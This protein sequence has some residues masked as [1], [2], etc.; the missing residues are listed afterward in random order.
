MSWK[1]DPFSAVDRPHAVRKAKHIGTHKKSG[2]Y[3]H[4]K[5]RS[6]YGTKT[7]PAAKDKVP[8]PRA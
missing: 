6:F 8:I 5:Y 4:M 3:H 1:H 7:N 2:Q